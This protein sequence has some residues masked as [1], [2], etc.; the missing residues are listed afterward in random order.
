MIGDIEESGTSDRLPWAAYSGCRVAF[1]VKYLIPLLVLDFRVRFWDFKRLVSDENLDFIKS[2]M[3]K[4]RT[5]VQEE[6][7]S[8]LI[9]SEDLNFWSRLMID[10]FNDVGR[11]AIVMAH[12]GTTIKYEG[13]ADSRASKVSMWGEMQAAY[14][15]SNGYEKNLFVTGHPH[16]A[17][18]CYLLGFRFR[19][20]LL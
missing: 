7:Y 13:V 5:Q 9:L 16:I 10:V 19:T 4:I 15:A 2:V 17:L 6:N 8:F 14:H 1:P 12:G 3:D 18:I 20:L 11:E